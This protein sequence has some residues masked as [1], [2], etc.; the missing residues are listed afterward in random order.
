MALSRQVIRDIIREAKDRFKKCE[1]WESEPQRRARDDQKFANGDSDN[2]YQWPNDMRRAREVMKRPV[3]TVN[4]IQLHN[5]LIVNDMKKNKPA[6]KI[7]PTGGGATKK[8]ADCYNGIIRHIEYQSNAQA[9]YDTAAEN[10]VECGIGYWRLIT[11]YVGNESLDQEI[12]IK[13][14]K[15]PFS[16]YC[17]PD[18]KEKDY[19]DMRYAFVF[20]S[21]QLDLFKQDNPNVKEDD[22]AGG[23][24]IRDSDWVDKEHVRI[25]E[26]FRVIKK[27]DT[28][29]VYI[30]DKGQQVVVKE[31][32]ID[33]RLAKKLKKEEGVRTRDFTYN[34]VEW[35]KIAGNTIYDST[36]WPGKYIPIIKLVGTERIID[37]RLERKGH[38]RYLKDAQRMYNY[39][40]SSEAESLGLQTKVPWTGPAKAVEGYEQYW[41]NANVI[42]YSYLP[43]NHID[44]KGNAIPAPS[45]PQPPASSEG[46][47]RGMENAARDMMAISGQ[48]E[49]MQGQPGNEVSGKA[50]SGRQRQGETATYHFVDNQAYAIQFTGKQ[51]IDVIPKIY[52]TRRIVRMIAPDGQESDV[53]IDPNSQQGYMEEKP[54]FEDVVKK[55]FNPTVGQYDVQADVGPAYAT[56]RQEAFDAYVKI[57]TQSPDLMKLIGDLAFRNADFPGAEDIADRLKRM[58]PPEVLGEGPT[59]NEQNMQQQI[60][61]LS[62]ML[63]QALQAA[64]EADRKA[65]ATKDDKEAEKYNAVTNRIK[66]VGAAMPPQELIAVATQVL[67]DALIAALTNQT[68]EQPVET[69]AGGAMGG[70]VDPSQANSGGPG[71]MPMNGAM[72]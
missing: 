9:A 60:Q 43:F 35:Y 22:V 36:I 12:F 4:K 5:A 1:E 26:Y 2:G 23:N 64:A 39:Y 50:I 48:F 27:Q 29:I 11:D 10:Q 53:T 61:N 66:V 52:D 24:T 32:S 59:P 58:V 54:P 49:A 71:A 6:I 33:S 42:S 34:I 14:V 41:F 40:A 17:D 15:N 51:L 3:L 63:E 30:D 45:R 31:S 44:D 7:L 28:L 69:P 21:Q 8:S 46:Y 67:H 25:C 18:A 62:Q 68:T 57:I 70:V 38:T 65:K 19:S 13:E 20:E 16:I 72:Q 56:R 55:I 47:Q 37:G